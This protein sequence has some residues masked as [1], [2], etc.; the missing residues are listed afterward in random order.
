MWTDAEKRQKFYIS[1]L[2]LK[3]RKCQ[4]NQILDPFL[5]ANKEKIKKRAM[6]K[7]KKMRKLS[8]SSSDSGIIYW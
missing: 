6:A 4:L 5:Q 2:N 7:K 3:V 1:L 8:D